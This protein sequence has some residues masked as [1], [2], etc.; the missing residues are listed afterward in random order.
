[1]PFYHDLKSYPYA[2]D[3]SHYDGMADWIARRL[4]TLRHDLDWQITSRRQPNSLIV[5]TWNI[6]AFDGGLPRLA[7]SFHYIAEIIAAFDIC[8]VQEVRD[9]LGPLKRLKG[10]LGPNWEYFVTDTS[11]HEGGNH[12]RMAF[13]YNTDK[14]FF[15]NLIGEIVVRSDA[16]PNGHQ[17]ARSPY[18]A[19]FQAGWFR[20]TLCSAHIVFGDE[21][22]AGLKLRAEE[23]RIITETL[24]KKARKEDQVYIFLGDMNIASKEGPVMTA[25]KESGLEVPAFEETNLGGTKFYDQIAYTVRGK[26]SRK[27]RLIRQGVFDWRR[28]VFGPMSPAPA[29]APDDPGNVERLDDAAQQAHY[30]PV[31][32]R[33]RTRHGKPPYEDFARSYNRWMSD[34]MSDHL[35]IWIELKTDYSNQYLERF[36]ATD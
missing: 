8:A 10:L 17:I 9:D 27:T 32:T 11:S 29:G 24:K 36:L 25:L 28:A 34:E 26:S 22:E 23:I 1:M 4:L 15:R 5:G 14:V 20:F 3:S 21:D 6:R 12:E 31:V 18:F 16:L 19:A 33:H 13:L 2:H 7:E 30:A 35:P